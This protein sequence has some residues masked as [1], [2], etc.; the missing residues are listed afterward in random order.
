MRTITIGR[1]KVNQIV[2]PDMSVSSEHAKIT[3][4]DNGEVYIKDLNSTNGTYVNGQKIYQPTRITATDNVE[5]S[6]VKLDWLKFLNAELKGNA[7]GKTQLTPGGGS[8]S[9]QRTIGRTAENNIVL[10][11]SNVS[12]NHARLVKD[13]NGQIT[14]IDNNSTNGTYVNGQRITSAVLHHG[15]SVM[16]ANQYPLQWETAFPASAKP[17]PNSQSSSRWII[18]LASIAA[19]AVAAVLFFHF[20]PIKPKQVAEQPWSADKIYSTYKKSVVMIF[21]AY[22]Y[23]VSSK[24]KVLANVTVSD[25][26]LAMYDGSNPIAYTGTGF[27]VSQDGKIVT[28]RHV[29][30]PWDYDGGIADKVKEY[31]QQYLAYLSTQNQEAFV[32]LQPM[33]GDIVVK[34]RLVSKYFGIFL[35]D[36]HVNSIDDLIHCTYLK[37]SN[38]QDIDVGMLQTNTKTLPSGVTTIVTRMEITPDSLKAGKKLYTIG[39]PEGFDLGRT[40]I[41]LEAN[42]QSGELT[43]VQGDVSFGHNMTIQHGASGSPVFNQYGKLVGVVNAGMEINGVSQG[44]NRAILAKHVANLLR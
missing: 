41:G 13:A 28:N 21:G 33:I 37:D 24:D 11:Y 32:K 35:N 9:N 25:G 6:K 29:V 5:V 22:Y 16:I 7:G 15:D 1:S 40:Q 12:H 44:Y 27:F 23:E 8:S 4:M 31:Y 19:L 2:I 3:I 39:F 18:W 20:N 17:K 26:K 14:I 42:N 30:C 34:G 38:N 10:S 36:T 43:Q